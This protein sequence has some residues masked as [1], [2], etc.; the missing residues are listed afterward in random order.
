MHCHDK[1]ELVN[2]NK[3]FLWEMQYLAITLALLAGT[4]VIRP[5][6]EID[7]GTA[8]TGNLCCIVE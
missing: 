3:P 5:R 8:A 7:S 4:S 1:R 6:W 2:L